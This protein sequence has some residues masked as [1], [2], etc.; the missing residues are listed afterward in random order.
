MPD[1]GPVVQGGAIAVLALVLW[2]GMRMAREMVKTT[3]RQNAEREQAYQEMIARSQ[4]AAMAAQER[5]MK[6]RDD[7]SKY[8]AEM[9]ERTIQS[10][11]SAM[12][13]MSVA[14]QNLSTTVREL[15]DTLADR[16]CLE[17][18]RFEHPDRRRIG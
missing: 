15:R 4:S 12:E 11:T 18:G 10:N 17:T 9:F 7:D 2:L 1:L 14:A 3:Q 5:A 6:T 16:P 13:H 8:R